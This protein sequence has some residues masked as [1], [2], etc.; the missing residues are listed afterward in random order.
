MALPMTTPSSNVARA[1]RVDPQQQ[2]VIG[3]E[4][5]FRA[6]HE[7]AGA[8]KL[9]SDETRLRVLSLL[10]EFNELNVRSLCDRLQQSQPA[11]SHHL[12]LL[13]SA[14]MIK[15]RRDGKHNYYRCVPEAIDSVLRRTH[16]RIRASASQ[17]AD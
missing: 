16:E 4:S 12:A 6:L 2:S 14:G 9:L 1:N 5:D 15:V 7:L 11:V 8:F 17:A 10:I 3:R 13:R